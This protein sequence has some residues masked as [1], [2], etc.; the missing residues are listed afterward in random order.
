[1]DKNAESEAP[2][3]NFYGEGNTTGVNIMDLSGVSAGAIIETD[4][5]YWEVQS[6]PNNL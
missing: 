3:L 4:E 6:N 5:N 1:M 2:G